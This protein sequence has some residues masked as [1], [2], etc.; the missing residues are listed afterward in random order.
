MVNLVAGLIFLTAAGLNWRYIER[1][2]SAM[3][4]GGEGGRRHA[5]WLAKHPIGNKI[6]GTVFLA[7]VGL[8]LVI[9]GL[10]GLI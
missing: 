9:S 8:A 1:L 3:W 4:G 5:S 2:S 10:A 6:G 7:F